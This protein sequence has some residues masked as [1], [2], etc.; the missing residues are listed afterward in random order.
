MKD[1]L[2][3]VMQVLETIEVH[4]KDNLRRLLACVNTLDEVL[5]ALEKD[6]K[7]DAPV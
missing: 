5:A 3:A 7:E 4:G 6:D 1:K 2:Q